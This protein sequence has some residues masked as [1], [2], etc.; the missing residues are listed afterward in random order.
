MTTSYQYYCFE[1]SC[2]DYRCNINGISKSDAI[3]LMEN[4]DLSEKKVEH[5]EIYIKKYFQV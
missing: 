1:N 4:V 2:Y 3:T 5:Y